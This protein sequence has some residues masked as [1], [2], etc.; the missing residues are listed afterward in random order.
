MLTRITKYSIKNIFRNKFLSL[1]SVIVLTL[2]MFFINILVIL[3]DVSFKLINSINSKLTISLYLDEKYNKNSVEVIDMIEDIKNIKGWIWNDLWIKV[4]YKTKEIILDEMREK[5]PWLVKILERNNPLPDTIVLSNIELNQY[6]DLNKAIENKM[7][8][9]SQEKSD[10]E[11][12][13]NYT[14]QYKK[15]ID[16]IN[17]LDV[18][19][20]WLYVI[21]SI[22][23][24][25]ISII[26]YSVIWNFIYYYRDEIYITRLV[27]WSRKFIYWPFVLQWWIYSFVAFVLSIFVFI[28]ILNNINRVFSDFYYFSY[29]FYIFM[30]EMVLFVFIWWMAWYLSSRKYL[31]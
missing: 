20:L 8:V 23:L 7:F 29:S 4:E 9:L 5:E 25:S 26:I 16:I 15:I 6:S 19:Q 14:S 13:A 27:W 2:L 12:F 31:K 17:I 24:V 22:F 21:I 28:I 18:L 30:I 10:L 3:H 11:Y 1:S